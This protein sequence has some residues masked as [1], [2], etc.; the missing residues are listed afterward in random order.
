MA[1]IV[2]ELIQFSGNDLGIVETKL[3]FFSNFHIKYFNFK[4]SP[5]AIKFET[6]F[7]KNV[8]LHLVYNL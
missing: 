5:I 3:I 4:S 1:H 6:H 2:S 8:L 7:E